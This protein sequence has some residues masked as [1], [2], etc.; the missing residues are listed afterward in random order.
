MVTSNLYHYYSVI[1]PSFNRADEIRKLLD[2]FKHVAFPRD[3]FELIIA[4]DGSQ[5]GTESLVQNKI[6]ETDITLRYFSQQNKGPGAARN[7]G[8]Q[9]AKGDFF[10][11]ID[12]DVTL[13]PDWLAKIDQQVNAARADAFGGPDTYRD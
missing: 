4:D 2:S 12:S 10:I 6:E 11:F 1:V 5:D 9:N 8:M 7:M 3:R 13:A